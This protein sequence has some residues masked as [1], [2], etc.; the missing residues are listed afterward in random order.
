MSKTSIKIET[1]TRI[2][3]LIK[4]VS[5]YNFV[6][7][8]HSKYNNSTNILEICRKDASVKPLVL[9]LANAGFSLYKTED[10][11]SKFVRNSEIPNFWHRVTSGEFLC[12]EG[13]I[14]HLELPKN[15]QCSRVL[16][17]FSS[18]GDDIF[19]PSLMRLFNFNFKS[20]S[21]F[22]PA[23]TAILRIADIGSVVGGF[24]LDTNSDEKFASRVLNLIQKI[25][26][27][28]NVKKE[29]VT[30]Y[31]ASKGATAALY[32]GVTGGYS[33]VVVDPIVSDEYY[34][35]KFNDSHFTIGTFP[36][37]KQELFSKILSEPSNCNTNIS[38]IYSDRSPQFQYIT[39]IVKASEA[40][41]KFSYINSNNTLIKD[42][43]DVS[44][45][46]INIAVSLINMSLY[47]LHPPKFDLT[48]I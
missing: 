12:H 37:T 30:L 7:V 25:Q 31:G 18:I 4:E 10:S 21:K 15:Q 33:A 22:V 16:V 1:G 39:S 47:N 11:V 5:A 24:Y 28:L 45:N 27:D 29:S 41:K 13:M 48:T 42:H 20:I 34:E 43:P 40:G 46:T 6:S 14:Y 23:D 38:L 19:N 44:P 32:H 2:S 17:T 36:Q 26:F 35:K 3:D 8:D 9:T